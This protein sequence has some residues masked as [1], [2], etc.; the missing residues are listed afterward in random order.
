MIFDPMAFGAGAL[1]FALAFIAAGGFTLVFKAIYQVV[2]PHNEGALIRA[3][4][5]A[6][7][8]ALGGAVWW[9]RRARGAGR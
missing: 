1:S 3:G 5:T 2:T 6:A 7:A 9:A 4:N 8:V